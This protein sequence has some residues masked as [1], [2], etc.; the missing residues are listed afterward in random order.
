MLSRLLAVALLLA[1]CLDARAGDDRL[2]ARFSEDLNTVSAELCFAGEAPNRLYRH[3]DAG[4]H[5][6]PIHHEGA[7]LPVRIAEDRVYLPDLPDDA[8]L[9]WTYDLGAAAHAGGYRTAFRAGDSV[10]AVTSLWYWKGP[11]TRPL[12][13]S[14]D[15]PED[16]HFS[17]PW[18][19]DSSDP[20]R[21]RPVQTP[22]GWYARSAVGRMRFQSLDVPGGEVELAILGNVTDAQADKLTRWIRR[23]VDAVTPVFG[24]FPRKHTQVVVVPIGARNEP[25]PW[26]HVVRG[27]G[28]GVQFYVD[29]TR[30]L[31][32][33]DADWTATHEFSHLLLPY[34]TR[35]DR[36]L[37]EG[38][39]SYYQ[40]VLRARD[41]RLSDETAWRKMHEGFERG[42]KATRRESLEEAT[43][44]GWRN[45]MR[46][47]WSG[48]AM[49]L[50]ADT[51]LRQRSGGRQSL[52]T[53]LKAL[54]DCCLADGKLWRASEVM[55]T[56]DRLTGMD[57]FMTVY[58][59]NVPRLAFPDVTGTFE[60]LG[61]D[62]GY[63][64]MEFE[65]EA[66]LTGVR[67]AIMTGEARPGRPGPG[68]DNA[69]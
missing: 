58:R 18:P 67:D 69:P 13:V 34:V 40:N 66:P 19:R 5:A 6:S 27:G 64:G 50:Q 68:S 9:S 51:I 46:V 10:L 62:P 24:F 26:A 33:F 41:G 53:A 17:T 11:W 32:E 22:S 28:P 36:W 38:L 20:K 37:S 52:D 25:V 45:T 7:T 60:L 12:V 43:R 54:H 49:M 4:N 55:E 65:E 1:P 23:S 31:T 61:L 14:V 39:A 8:C 42:R 29:E 35:R 44:G 21:Y 56:L 59:E 15:L 2:H 3:N 57:V 30:P 48:A 47:Y 16:A 63:R